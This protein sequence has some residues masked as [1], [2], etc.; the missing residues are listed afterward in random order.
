[1]PLDPKRVQAVFLSA[2]E[3]DDA[4]A[5]GAVLDR[6]CSYD[7]ELRRRVEALLLARDE[8]NSLLDQPIVNPEHRLLATSGESLSDPSELTGCIFP[9]DLESANELSSSDG[10]LVGSGADGTL[11]FKLQ[12]DPTA[13]EGRPAPT[14]SGYEILGELGRGGT[15]VVYKA[16]Q[17]RLNRPSA[18][19]MILGGGHASAESAARFVAEAQAIAQLQ[20]PHIVQIH[21][22]GEADGLPFFELEYVSGGSVDR[23]LDGTPW[24]ARRAAELIQLLARGVAEA[25][26]Q[27]IVHRDLK[28]SNILLA[29]DG[30]PKI[31]DFGLAKSLVS[32]S[33]LTRTDSIMGS[34][35][36]MS[37]EQAEGHGHHAGPAADVYS[38][39]AILYELLTGAPP[40]RGTTVG[41]PVGCGCCGWAT[42]S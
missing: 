31:T 42:P 24:P 26:R 28:P 16:R 19:K 6:E 39:G 17:I 35:G 3:C 8:P 38:L 33:G 12:P 37:P 40:F 14:V 4:A 2:V 34:P 9:D 1:M 27:G 25:H 32:D 18:L 5:R 23:R 21:H 11:F 13:S 30:T 7:P 10:D 41:P 22:I 20:H 36:Y 29:A 15:G